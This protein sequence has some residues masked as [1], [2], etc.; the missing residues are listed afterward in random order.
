MTTVQ[1]VT[2][3]T[4]VQGQAEALAAVQRLEREIAAGR[5]LRRAVGL[6]AERLQRY[7]RT[8]THV[9]TG[10]LQASHR[11][12]YTGPLTAEVSLDRAARNL[13]DGRPYVYGVYEHARGGGHAF[14]ARTV[15]EAGD[16]ALAAAAGAFAASLP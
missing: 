14:Y 15:A 16:S 7:A 2:L 5:G 11:S 9:D 1:G 3:K 10:E 8:V 6:A 4:T 12:L 13:H